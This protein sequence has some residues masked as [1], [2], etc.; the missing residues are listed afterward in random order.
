[1]ILARV[2]SRPY[3]RY[4]AAWTTTFSIA[5]TIMSLLLPEIN[6][7]HDRRSSHRGRSAAGLWQQRLQRRGTIRRSAPL[8][9]GRPAEHARWCGFP[10]KPRI[11]VDAAWRRKYDFLAAQLGFMVIADVGQ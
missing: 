2:A 11:R 3:F 7:G 6:D 9:A 5:T 1:L 10:E 8:M 4:H